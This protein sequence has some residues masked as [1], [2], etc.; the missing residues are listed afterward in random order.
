MDLF[1]WAEALKKR[2]MDRAAEAE[3][4]RSP[5][6]QTA[7]VALIRSIAE[8]QPTVH[9]DDVLAASTLEPRHHNAWGAVWSR[10][11]KEGVIA[12]T[13]QHRRCKSDTKKHAHD[14]PVYRSLV[15]RGH[16]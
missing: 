5:G 12:K 14:Y 2:G 8:Q 11:I 10:A 3:E 16:A 7:A 4:R 9:V 15:F 13:G 6:F 1:A